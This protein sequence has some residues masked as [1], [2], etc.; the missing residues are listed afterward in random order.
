MPMS[1]IVTVVVL[2]LG[3]YIVLVWHEDRLLY[4]PAHVPIPRGAS[5]HGPSRGF[6][7]GYE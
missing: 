3:F 1:M 5:A 6:A 4:S 7:Y 2:L